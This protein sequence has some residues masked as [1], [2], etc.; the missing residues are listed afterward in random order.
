MMRTPFSGILKNEPL[1]RFSYTM[2]KQQ[3]EK[4][5]STTETC[6]NYKKALLTI[7]SILMN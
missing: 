5:K 2:S 4:G 1:Y 6:R 3:L 7:K